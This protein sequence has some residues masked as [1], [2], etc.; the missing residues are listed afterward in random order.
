MELEHEENVKKIKR[1]SSNKLNELN[2]MM[3]STRTALEAEVANK[4][5]V[6]NHW[7]A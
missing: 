6:R 7:L 3:M 5:R 1:E 2:E 4:D